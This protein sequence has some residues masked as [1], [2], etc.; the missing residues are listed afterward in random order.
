MD[1]RERNIILFKNQLIKTIDNR[2]AFGKKLIEA[3]L[4]SGPFDILV[5]PIVNAFYEV[6]SND[7]RRGILKQIEII[8]NCGIKFVKR[9]ESEGEFNS[10]VEKMFLEYLKGDQLSGMCK[11]S[12]K[13]YSRLK[14]VLRE[15]F[16]FQI[17]E[18]MILLSVR[19]DV[20]TYDDLV[21]A[22]FKTK[23]DAYNT[24]IKQL[25]SYDECLR[26]MERDLSILNFPTG[27]KR[28]FNV[29]KKGS[30][31]SNRDFIENLDEVYD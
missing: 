18:S 20:S 17:K 21:R 29:L 2:I 10:E 6:Y 14:N 4:K 16:I 15:V 22:A 9:E 28:I 23:E 27:R 5:K 19:E 30:L 25:N 7:A 1:Q 13:N 24:L 31:K 3:E 8:L 12:H 11:K 26:I